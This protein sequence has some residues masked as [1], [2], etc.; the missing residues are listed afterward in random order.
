MLHCDHVPARGGSASSTV[1][2]ISLLTHSCT[3]AP[4]DRQRVSEALRGG[5][6]RHRAQPAPRGRRRSRRTT[7]SAPRAR[8][9]GH[10]VPLPALW[11]P[12]PRGGAA[13][14]SPPL[15]LPLRPP[16]RGRPG[17]CPAGP[18][19]R[20]RGTSGRR[21]RGRAA[22]ALDAGRLEGLSLQ[23]LSALLDDEERLQGMAR[24]M[25]EV[26]AAL[27]GR[28]AGM[29]FAL[30]APWGSAACSP[31]LPSVL[32][33]IVRRPGRGGLTAPACCW[34][35][36]AEVRVAPRFSLFVLGCF[37]PLLGLPPHSPL[38]FLLFPPLFFSCLSPLP[39]FNAALFFT[40]G[41]AGG[42]L[43][44]RSGCPSP[45]TVRRAALCGAA[46]P[47]AAPLLSECLCQRVRLRAVR[48]G[49]RLFTLNNPCASCCCLPPLWGFLCAS[50]RCIMVLM[51]SLP[52]NIPKRLASSKYETA[53][54]KILKEMF[55][56]SLALILI[57]FA[58]M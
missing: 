49:L 9:C 47:A 6:A 53:Y 15:P 18:G 20:G 27:R 51:E 48:L 39:P 21:E 40:P 37:F 8:L 52:A 30:G 44:G 2:P 25:E 23:E 57:P 58:S 22:M 38:P 29:R 14:P 41:P 19:R 3:R 45:R 34:G 24:E 7:R 54:V 17:R 5:T 11:V 35:A 10:T 33:A 43:S 4:T 56:A 55:S 13:R 1:T 36:A 16:G 42:V 28:T 50:E 32:P 26:S 46:R 31:L 12:P